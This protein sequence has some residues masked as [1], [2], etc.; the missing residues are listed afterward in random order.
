[1]SFSAEEIYFDEMYTLVEGGPDG[2]HISAGN[3]VY[4]FSYILP[5]RTLPSRFYTVYGNVQYKIRAVFIRSWKFN[6]EDELLFSIVSP[7][8]LNCLPE[9]RSPSTKSAE[10]MVSSCLTSSGSI[11]LTVWLPFTGFSVGQNINVGTRIQNMS[12]VSV[13]R[14]VYEIIQTIEFMA[15]QPLVKILS[16]KKSI[17]MEYT[18]CIDAHAEK[19]WTT[20]LTVSEA[21][22]PNL[23][24]CKIISSSYRLK[25][26]AILPF[27][28]SNI[29]ISQPITFGTVPLT[30]INTNICDPCAQL[31]SSVAAPVSEGTPPYSFQANAVSDTGSS[32]PQPQSTAP[33]SYEEATH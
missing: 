26:K 22:T 23:S 11:I 27:P 14:V 13:E 29:K 1:M 31:N 32:Q 15:Q 21:E 4:P 7:V 16:I 33:P 5:S 10:E 25:V 18:N 2:L 8:D 19:S 20:S 30:G 28:H 3:H 6:Y 17:A 24:A 9:V 12:N